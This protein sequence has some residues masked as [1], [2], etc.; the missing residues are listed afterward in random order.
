[1]A[2]AAADDETHMH[3]DRMNTDTDT[4]TDTHTPAVHDDAVAE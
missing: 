4:D 2:D 3:T 1:M